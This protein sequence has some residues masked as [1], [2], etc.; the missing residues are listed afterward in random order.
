MQF[1]LLIIFMVYNYPEKQNA[2]FIDMETE[3]QRY[4][5]QPL[6]L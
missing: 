3:A 6:S 4:F 2:H 1:A 5:D